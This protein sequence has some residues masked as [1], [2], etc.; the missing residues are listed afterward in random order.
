MRIKKAIAQYCIAKG[1]STTEDRINITA[2]YLQKKN[3]FSEDQIL[4]A[5]A[6]L[7]ETSKYFPDVSDVL[8]LLR[9]SQE[10]I[11]DEGNLI[12]GEII[13]SLSRFG[14]YQ[15]KEARESLG[16]T[17]WY[18]V[19]RFGGW[20]TVCNLTYSELGTARA[21]MRRLAEASVRARESG[22]VLDF[23]RRASKDL[24]QLE[25]MNFDNI[26]SLVG[27]EEK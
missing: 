25:K 17:A 8:K 22:G 24:R 14:Q 7:F 13:D 12:A 16:E 19:E 10:S 20:T 3:E 26:L 2:T 15:A 6:Q 27:E 5:I 23:S 18:V 9:P 11:A 21:Q 1:I 4:W